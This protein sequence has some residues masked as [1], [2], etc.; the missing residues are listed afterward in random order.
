MLENLLVPGTRAVG[1]VVNTV[2]EIMHGM[3]LGAAGMHNQVR[4]WAG[5]GFLSGLICRL[6]DEHGVDLVILAGY[7]KKLGPATLARF[8]GRVLNI[9]PA[10][11][12]AFGGKGMYGPRVHKTVIASGA[13]VSGVTVHLA[14]EEYDRGPIVAQEVVPVAFDDTPESLAARVLEVEHRIY[15]DVIRAFAEGRVRLHG[16]RVE[17]LADS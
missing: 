10:L 7:M 2:D 12:P 15:A 3:Q 5:G 1:L 16:T 11:L 6:L 13:K 9:H 17:V 14:D 8:R 4:Q